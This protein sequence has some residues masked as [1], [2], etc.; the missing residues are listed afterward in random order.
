LSSIRQV[1]FLG[2]HQ[3]NTLEQAVSAIKNTHVEMIGIAESGVLK[4]S[5]IVGNARSGIF[6]MPLFTHQ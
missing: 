4:N 1:L 6:F 3:G 5:P 2:F